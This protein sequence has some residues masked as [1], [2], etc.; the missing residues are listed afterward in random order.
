MAQLPA[1]TCEKD[2]IVAYVDGELDNV[3]STAF[4]D[5]IAGCE[6]CRSELTEHKMLICALDSVLNQD[7]NVGI[8]VDFSRIVAAHAENDMRGVRSRAEHRKA[9]LFSILLA[10]FAFVL[11]GSSARLSVFSFGRKMLAAALRLAEF[12]WSMV[13][14][15]LAG[16][17]AVFRVVSRDVVVDTRSLGLLLLLLA[18]AVLSLSRLISH[19]HRSGAVE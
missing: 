17:T 16:L 9:L 2:L 14:D 18:L 13:Y 5:H 3:A 6:E 15:A 7:P 11:L 10:S 8:P 1:Q 4:E 12:L 19:Y